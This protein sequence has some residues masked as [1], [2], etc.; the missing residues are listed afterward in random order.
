MKIEL[1]KLEQKILCL[2]LEIPLLGGDDLSEAFKRAGVKA[3]IK[4]P[5][6]DEIRDMLGLEPD[7]DLPNENEEGMQEIISSLQEEANDKVARDLLQR[8]KKAK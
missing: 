6:P 7:E 3:P 5:D 2:M 4:M 1:S 8:I